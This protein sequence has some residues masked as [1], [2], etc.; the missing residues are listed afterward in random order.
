MLS[1]CSLLSRLPL[2]S[3][4]GTYALMLQADEGNNFMNGL[5]LW[6]ARACWSALQAPGVVV[7]C[8]LRCVLTEMNMDTA[9][10]AEAVLLLL[11]GS[12]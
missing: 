8:A 2:Q 10:V 6:A 11:R 7:A 4:V 1:G 3:V 5:L 9:A 12:S